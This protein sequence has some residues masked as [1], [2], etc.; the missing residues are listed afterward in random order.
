MCVYHYLFWLQLLWLTAIIGSLTWRLNR[1]SVAVPKIDGRTQFFSTQNRHFDV[2]ALYSSY[3]FFE[4]SELADMLKR[5]LAVTQMPAALMAT[6]HLYTKRSALLLW[7]RG[8]VDSLC[9]CE[10]QQR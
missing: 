4:R 2:F 7:N 9:V 10:W 5:A 8:G 1:Q 6:A 3:E